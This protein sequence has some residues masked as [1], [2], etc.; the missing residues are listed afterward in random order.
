[1]TNKTKSLM[2]LVAAFISGIGCV[3]YT[4]K[5]EHRS[6]VKPLATVVAD[7]NEI[8]F[9]YKAETVEFN[10]FIRQGL[11]AQETPPDYYLQA[12]AKLQALNIDSITSFQEFNRLQSILNSYHSQRLALGMKAKQKTALQMHRFLTEY[13]RQE[14]RV[15]ELQSR[16]FSLL[17]QRQMLFASPPKTPDN[18]L[19]AFLF[20]SD[21]P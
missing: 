16:C 9:R 18:R 20:A 6:V 5:A 7:L 2:I 8:Q 12:L 1:M 21:S 10:Q 14:T 3:Q 19:V 13:S 4:H 11:F 17:Q 15:A